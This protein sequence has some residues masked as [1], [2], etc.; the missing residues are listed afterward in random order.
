MFEYSHT[1][2]TGA[3]LKSRIS[4]ILRVG[5]KVWEEEFVRLIL[6]NPTPIPARRNILC[7]RFDKGV[8]PA[9]GPSLNVNMATNSFAILLWT[10]S[11]TSLFTI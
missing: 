10:F 2:H 5:E 1:L 4:C 7:V 9:E 8:I 3:Y 11:R 6:S